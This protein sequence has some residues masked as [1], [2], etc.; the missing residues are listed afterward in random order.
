MIYRLNKFQ[1]QHIF[2]PAEEYKKAFESLK[3]VFYVEA[4]LDSRLNKLIIAQINAETDAINREKK[5]LQQEN[6]LLL[7]DK[8]KIQNRN[9]AFG[10]SGLVLTLLVF[11]LLVYKNT[12][13]KQRLAEQEK[14]L[15]VQKTE[16][17]LAEQELTS[18]QAMIAGQEKE[19]ELVA[20][21][22]HNS[23]AGTI[24]AARLKLEFINE[25]KETAQEID[26]NLFDHTLS[27]LKQAHD[28]VRSMAHLKNSGV[29]A[30]K[31]L[32]PAIKNLA[33]NASGVK[34]LTVDVQEFGL[35]ERIDN[36]L[37]IRIFRTVQE[38]INNV[39][40][41]AEASEATIALTRHE[42]SLSIIVEDNGK[43]FD[44]KKILDKEGMGLYSMEKQIEQ[45]NG[46]LQIDSSPGNGTT[47]LIDIPV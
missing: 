32:L 21:D 34:G 10:L 46:S 42:N 2:E 39:I 7:K 12:K 43:G 1:S 22:L 29:I 30:T 26:P 17:I 18:L 20:Q 3:E 40:K 45:I 24:N 11:G 36:S 47:V 28:E 9:I 27:L 38:L 6:D 35:T 19:R 15:E 14:E 33:K 8:Q 41:H 25:K 31:G 5:I 23:V 37:E 16:K 4:E 44:P 13:R